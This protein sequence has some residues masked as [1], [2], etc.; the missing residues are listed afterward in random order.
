MPAKKSNTDTELDLLV[1]L[2]RQ[3]PPSTAYYSHMY[4]NTT[5]NKQQRVDRQVFTEE[6]KREDFESSQTSTSFNSAIK[7]GNMK[8]AMIG[9]TSRHLTGST[10]PSVS[11]LQARRLSMGLGKLSCT[12]K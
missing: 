7:L 2:S 3:E 4:R 12:C 6:R 9:G 1:N 5:P 10:K 8:L 11:R